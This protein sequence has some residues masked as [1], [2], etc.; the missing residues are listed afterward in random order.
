[1]LLPT[2]AGKAADFG[3]SSAPELQIYT[4]V[5]PLQAS[6]RKFILKGILKLYL[7]IH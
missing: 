4:Y 6:E 2:R 7:K 3:P 1:M 5:A